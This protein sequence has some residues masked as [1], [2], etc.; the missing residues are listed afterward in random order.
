M[1]IKA[2]YITYNIYTL[3]AYFITKIIDNYFN[4]SSYNCYF[5]YLSNFNNKD[6]INN[7]F[8]IYI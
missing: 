5:S 1:R 7:A 8:N 3:L 2:I 6:N 4:K